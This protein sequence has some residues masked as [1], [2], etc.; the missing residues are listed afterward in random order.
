MLLFLRKIGRAT[1]EHRWTRVL[2]SVIDN[3]DKH[4]APRAASAIAFDAFLSLIPLVALAGHVLSRLHQSTAL[5]LDPLIRAAPRDVSQLVTSEFQ[6]MADSSVV[7]PL[8]VVGFVWV[9]SSGLSTAMGV[10]ETIYGSTARP[11]YH[12]RALAA[13]CVLASL[14]GFPA[15]AMLGVLLATI[16]GSTGAQVVALALPAGLLVLLVA[17]FFR[18]AIAER[19]GLKRPVFPGAA[20]TVVLWVVVSALFSLYVARLARYTTFYGNLATAA[21]FLFWLWLLALA[22]FVGGELNARLERERTTS[23]PPASGRSFLRRSFP[24]PR[25][26]F[27]PPRPESNQDEDGAGAARSRTA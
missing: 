4:D 17:A 6:R 26:S 7:A 14:V 13:C 18:I 10:F 8:S 20:L 11:W 27:P 23:I 19:P 12:R 25:P 16:S 9:S 22:L 1:V 15:V 2:R 24:P 5:F 3:L 21:I